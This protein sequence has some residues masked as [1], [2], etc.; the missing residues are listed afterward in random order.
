MIGKFVFYLK[1]L[2]IR[3]YWKRTNTHNNTYLGSISNIA[4]IK[5]IR[6]NGIIVGNSTYG[7]INVNYT[8]AEDE[9]LIIGS[10]CSIS[11]NCNFLLGG[12]HDYKRLSTFP[13]FGYEDVKATTK[14]KIVVEDD[15]WIGDGAWILSGLTL[16]KGSIIA[17]GSIVTKD[18]PP[19]AIVGGN[20]ARILKYRFSDDIITKIKN[21]Y[22][23]YNR[24]N[25]AQVEALKKQITEDNVDE[26]I[27]NFL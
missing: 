9:K 1:K 13:L 25:S 17:T 14:G 21:V 19:Y 20:P 26:I 7:R 5:F 10:N 12:G 23:D 11:G 24:L 18:V 3:Y 15:V 6:N 4:A 27:K 8:G 22:V 2:A 16:G